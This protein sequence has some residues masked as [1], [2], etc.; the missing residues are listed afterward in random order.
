[1][2][3]KKNVKTGFPILEEYSKEGHDSKTAILPEIMM[4]MMILKYR[5]I[6]VHQIVKEWPRHCSLL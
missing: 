6:E 5:D 4:M 3:K 2:Q 1:M